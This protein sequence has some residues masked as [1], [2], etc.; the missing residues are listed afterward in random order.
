MNN[1]ILLNILLLWVT[2]FWSFKL[3]NILAIKTS[4]SI[5]TFLFFTALIKLVWNSY[6]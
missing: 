6:A 2:I 4:I 3:G 5:P 1:I